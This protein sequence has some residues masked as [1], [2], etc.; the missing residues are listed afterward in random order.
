MKL[1]KRFLTES[2]NVERSAALWNMIGSMTNA[3]QSVILLMVMTHTV[4]LVPAGI[5]TMGN[6]DSNLFLSI[7]KYGSRS[8]QVSD[9]KKEYVFR[10]YRMS[11]IITC[12]AMALVS[13]L[14]V[15]WVANRNG[16]SGEKTSIILWMCIYK[17]PDAFEDIYQAEYQKND[18]LDVAAKCLALRMIL[19]IVLWAILIFITRNLLLSTIISTIFTIAVCGFFIILTRAFVSEKNTYSMKRVWKLLLVMSPLC[20]GSFLTIY[21]G[22]APRNSI[23]RYL[24]DELQAIYGFIS[25]PVFVV[26]LLVTFIFNPILYKVSLMWDEHKYKEYLKSSL[27]QAGLV[28]VLT[29][30]CVAGAW[31]LGI[32]VLSLMYKTD[33]APYK[34]DLLMM[35]LGSGFLGFVAL[36]GQL[37]TVMRSQNEMLIGY[38]LASLVAFLFSDKA[39]LANGISGACEFYTILLFILAIIFVMLYALKYIRASRQK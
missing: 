37:L 30:V 15:L 33:L 35:M 29:L 4:G 21:I 2:D 36:L 11:R 22:A 13:T 20:I 6:T 27:I 7:G 23:D 16:Y 25:M 10:E 14:Y 18:R 3:F 38:G 39:V 5:Y 34:S 17:L 26:Q 31:L 24:N 1:L 19:T 28:I 9:V 32:P 12:I 8:F